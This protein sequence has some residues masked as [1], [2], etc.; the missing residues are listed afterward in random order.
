MLTA[1]EWTLWYSDTMSSMQPLTGAPMSESSTAPE[2]GASKAAWIPL[3]V[4]DLGGVA[5]AQNAGRNGLAESSGY[6]VLS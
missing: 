4:C 5:A 3:E 2:S 6:T 1:L